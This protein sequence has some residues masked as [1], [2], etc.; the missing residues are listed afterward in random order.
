MGEL[1]D[2]QEAAQVGPRTD[3]L[4]GGDDLGHVDS[5]CPDAF[6]VG[7]FGR[8]GGMSSGGVE[9][10]GQPRRPGSWKCRLR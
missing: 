8:G 6:E 7:P 1:S 10:R 5:Q 2:H 9:E 4:A 3:A